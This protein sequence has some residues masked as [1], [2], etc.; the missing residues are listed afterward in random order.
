MRINKKVQ[1]VAKEWRQR[2]NETGTGGVVIV[3]E[4]QV[5]GFTNTLRHP[6]AW[7]QGTWAVEENGRCFIAVGGD[8]TEYGEEWRE[9]PE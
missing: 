5:Q 3:Y 6:S 4:G 7:P 9:V 2:W 8:D 1:L